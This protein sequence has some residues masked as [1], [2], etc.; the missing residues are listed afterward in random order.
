MIKTRIQQVIPERRGITTVYIE[1]YDDVTGVI[2][3]R[4]PVQGKSQEEIKFKI[5][6]QLL[7][8][9]EKKASKKIVVDELKLMIDSINEES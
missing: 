7:K 5:K 6:E 2:K 8:L 4:S 3:K 1:Y 9:K